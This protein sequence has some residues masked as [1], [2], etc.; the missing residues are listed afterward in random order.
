MCVLSSHTIINTVCRPSNKVSVKYG[1]YG[2]L[3]VSALDC[4]RQVPLGQTLG[5]FDAPIS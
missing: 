2:A 4:R 1:T 5:D 3:V